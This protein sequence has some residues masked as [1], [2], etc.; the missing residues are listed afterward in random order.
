MQPD[1]LIPGS[2]RVLREGKIHCPSNAS[3]GLLVNW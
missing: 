3:I 2:N 1:S